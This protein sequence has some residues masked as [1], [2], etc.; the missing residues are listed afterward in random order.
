MMLTSYFLVLIRFLQARVPTKSSLAQRVFSLVRP[1]QSVSE[2]S[3]PE[4]E[5]GV[6]VVRMHVYMYVCM[7]D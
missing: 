1:Q 4:S 6:E 7:C 3:I 2:F 5:S